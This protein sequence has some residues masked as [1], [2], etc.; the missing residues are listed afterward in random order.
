[1]E[2]IDFSII[3]PTWNRAHLIEE[4]LNSL[5]TDRKGYIYGKTEVLIID[6]SE[7]EQKGKIQKSCQVHD[8]IYIP[9]VESVRKKRNKGITTAKYDYIFFIDS[10]VTIKPG[11]LN[12]HAEIYLKNQDNPRLGGTFGIT[13]FVGPKSLLWEIIELTGFVDPF[14][15]AKK[16]QYVSWTIGNNVT[17]RK[18]ILLEIGMFEEN[19]PFKLGGDDLDMT[20]RVTKAGYLIKT[21]PE[22]VTY[23]SRETWNHLKAVNDRCKRWG[24]MEYHLLKR[25]PELQN[26]NLPGVIPVILFFGLVFAILAF[27]DN[28]PKV[29]WF[30]GLWFLML[31]A[32]FYGRD[33]KQKGFI[34]PVYW[35]IAKALDEKYKIHKGVEAIKHRDLAIINTGMYFGMSHLRERY[36]EETIQSWICY[37]T[38][39]ITILAMI[40]FRIIR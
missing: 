18:D 11:M 9:G 27:I 7:G 20:Y 3:I 40:I 39:L 34:N 4:L 16:Y 36:H 37:I 24:T 2:Q 10:D 13:E 6:N 23:H 21:V 29:F 26:R 33:V 1:M 5:E 22:A 28:T 15:F 12:H 17:F 35:L 38:L 32:G 19:L 31:F 14:A 30:Y 8:A 25:H